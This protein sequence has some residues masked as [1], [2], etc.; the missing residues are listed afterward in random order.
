MHR[1]SPHEALKYTKDKWPLH[2]CTPNLKELNLMCG[3][4]WYDNLCLM[5]DAE[6]W[7]CVIVR[8]ARSLV[9]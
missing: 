2:V 6:N 8:Q 4:N 1:H 7:I 9:L 3:L 5:S